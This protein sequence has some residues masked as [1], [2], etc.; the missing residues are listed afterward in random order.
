M[1][2][3]FGMRK[4]ARLLDPVSPISQA[5]PNTRILHP[6]NA[7]HDYIFSPCHVSLSLHPPLT[8]RATS[9]SFSQGF[10]PFPPPLAP[11]PCL[12]VFARV[13]GAWE[14]E[15]GKGG[16]TR[17]ER[18]EDVAL[19]TLSDAVMRDVVRRKFDMVVPPCLLYKASQNEEGKKDTKRP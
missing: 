16:E 7:S 2:D 18:E 5:H 17:H 15:R 19:L 8:S 6:H 14:K 4:A 12:A 13:A 9:S 3:F 1:G 11:F 10:L